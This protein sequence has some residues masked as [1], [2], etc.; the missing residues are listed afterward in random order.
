LRWENAIEWWGCRIKWRTRAVILVKIEKP[1][2]QG[3]V[4]TK[5][6][7]EADSS[8]GGNLFEV[9]ETQ[10]EVVGMR[11]QAAHERRVIS[12]KIGKPS[13]WGSF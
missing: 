8:M 6:L 7:Q 11:D 10:F 13:R 3:S 12:V 1:S 9:G 5:K 4:F 2:R